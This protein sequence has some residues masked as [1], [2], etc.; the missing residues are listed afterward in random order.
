M[1]DAPKPGSAK[2]KGPLG[3][4]WWVWGV[5]GGA[6]LVAAIYFYRKRS[7][8]QATAGSPCTDANGN[9]GTLDANGNC[10][11]ATAAAQAGS[12][13]GWLLNQQA[14][15]SAAPQPQPKPKPVKCPKGMAWD[16]DE[17]KCVPEKAGGGGHRRRRHPKAA[18][19]QVA[20][21][22]GPPGGGPQG[23]PVSAA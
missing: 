3:Q 23:V 7:Q 20:A 10:V 1:A 4:P 21:S 12:F 11:A 2:A 5:A 17:H 6:V 14:S 8:Q 15:P 19:A 18:A 22:S 16:P 13:Y 9:S